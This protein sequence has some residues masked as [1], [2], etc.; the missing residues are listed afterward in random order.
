MFNFW[1]VISQ[2]KVQGHTR[3]IADH[4]WMASSFIVFENA[5]KINYLHQQ[6][7]CYIW[8]TELKW[9]S[10]WNS[11]MKILKV[12]RCSAFSAPT[13][14]TPRTRPKHHGV[15]RSSAVLYIAYSRLRLIRTGFAD[16]FVRAGVTTNY[17][18]IS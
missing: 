6:Q 9:N 13:R 7:C 5:E 2:I 3:H 8:T 1:C 15:P 12:L 16:V 10:L 11:F 17:F 14:S 18:V 4:L